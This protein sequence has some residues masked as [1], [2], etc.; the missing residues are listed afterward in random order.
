[1]IL[2]KKNRNDVRFFKIKSFSALPEHLTAKI[3]ANPAIS[4]GV[5]ETSIL[6]LDPDD[7]MKLD[8]QNS[9][10]LIST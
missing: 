6:R 9:I 1:M 8:E 2:R 10:I 4:D 3:Y 5:D 7:K